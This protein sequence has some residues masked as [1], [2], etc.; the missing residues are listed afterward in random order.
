MT[1]NS[2]RSLLIVGLLAAAPLVTGADGSGCGRAHAPGPVS[3]GA[4]GGLAGSTGAGTG[5][6]AA[7]SMGAGTG[8]AAG[9]HLADAGTAPADGGAACVSK[10]GE[11]CGGNT[12][13]P[14]SCAAGL[15]CMPALG[16]PAPGDVGG[17]CKAADAGAD[18]DGGAADAGSA[19]DGGAACVS[20]DGE[21]CGG[22]IAH[23]CSCASGLVC[24]PSAGGPPAGDVG[25]TCKPS[26]HAGSCS[27]DSDCTLKADYCTGC[28]CV[29]LAPGQSVKPCSGPGVQCFV[30]PCGSKTAACQNG[31]CV[32]R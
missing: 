4:G 25:G 2:T 8:S 14:C 22:N 31:A 17:T 26:A 19:A 12:M 10:Q 21:H 32:S 11:H 23:P 20:K 3:A 16:G 13:R 1:W 7:G 15:M 30:D 29:A 28:D 27:N 5:S 18:A 24:T 9:G 6:G